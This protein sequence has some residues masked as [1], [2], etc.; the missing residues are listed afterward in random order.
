[1]NRLKELLASTGDY[2]SSRKTTILNLVAALAVLLLY[3]TAAGLVIT[4]IVAFVDIFLTV[5]LFNSP[6]LSMILSFLGALG[7]FLT[8]LFIVFLRGRSMMKARRA[9]FGNDPFGGLRF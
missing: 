8:A 2:L 6:F 7:S 4:G 1:M 9:Q 5:T 3:L